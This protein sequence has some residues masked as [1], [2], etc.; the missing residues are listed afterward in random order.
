MQ[1]GDSDGQK[2][3]LDASSERDGQ[4]SELDASSERDRQK[5]ELDA[6]SEHDVH[7]VG[8]DNATYIG[9]L[10]IDTRVLDLEKKHCRVPG[11]R[12]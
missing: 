1:P 6:S 4:K 12:G 3:E 5:S 9:D 2:S 8:D 7:S 10:K 11:W